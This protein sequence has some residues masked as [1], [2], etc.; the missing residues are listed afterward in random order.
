MSA[1][2]QSQKFARFYRCALQVNPFDY[3]QRHAVPTAPKNE[4]IYNSNLIAALEHNNIEAI[5]VTDH[6]RVT[7]SERLTEAARSKGIHAFRGFEAVTKDG[8]HFLCIFDS[9]ETVARLERFIGECGVHDTKSPSPLGTLD[10]EQ[11][12][13]RVPDWG[14]ICVAAHVVSDGGILR[15]LKGTSRANLWKS[16]LLVACAL[17]GSPTSAPEDLKRILSNADP[18]YQ[19]RWPMAFIN[20]QDLSDATVAG[21][22]SKSCLI[23]MTSPS[24][25][26]LRQAF[27]DSESRIRLLSEPT[28]VRNFELL[29]I[30]WDGG[31]LDGLGIDFSEHLNCVI[32]GRGTG[33]STLIESIRAVFGIKPLGSEATKRH[34]AIVQHVIR[35]GTKITARVAIHRPQRTEYTIE[36]ILPDAP[37]VRTSDG[38]KTKLRP[39]ELVPGFEIYG[40]HEIS[41]LAS[42]PLRL[43]ELLSR[44]LPSKGEEWFDLPA[45]QHELQRSR[46][47]ID[48]LGKRMAGLEDR[49]TSLPRLQEQKERFE[50]AG[51][52][53]VLAEQTAVISEAA[54]LVAFTERL[55]PFKQLLDEFDELLPV[56]WEDETLSTFAESPLKNE[57][58]RM[59]QDLLIF[60]RSAKKARDLLAKSIEDADVGDAQVISKHSERKE[61]ITKKTSSVFRKLG[62]AS[63]DGQVYIN[64]KTQIA[65]LLPLEPQLQKLKQQ[66]ADQTSTRDELVRRLEDRKAAQYRALEKAAKSV[67]KRL[68]GSVRVSVKFQG[69]REPLWKQ[70]KTAGGRWSETLQALDANDSIT[71]TGLARSIR[72]GVSSLQSNFKLPRASAE[73]LAGLSDSEVMQLEETTLD[74]TTQIELNVAPK[75]ADPIWRRLDQLSAGQRATAVLLLLLLDNPAPLIVDQP[76]D[77]LDNRFIYDGIVPKLRSEKHSRQF[78]FATHNANIPVLGDA[79]LIACFQATGDGVSGRAELVPENVGSID[80]PELRLLVEQVLEGGS[81]AF[82]MRRKKYRY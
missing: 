53:Q 70:L 45:I 61:E 4:D 42:D 31:F 39:N 32:G 72:E 28:P 44:F 15:Q 18:V 9:G 21:E 30:Q 34:E 12:L 41:E 73:R 60:N 56:Q 78:I 38:K 2:P 6:Y 79:E 3:V 25:E 35:P 40:Q 26:A 43:T 16:E 74:H 57:I 58:A 5:C 82:E 20:A 47:G 75:T 10:S 22:F 65:Q 50:K 66:F 69:A 8:V 14:G 54:E 33:K 80:M 7:T 19:R 59:K 36:R 23:K 37:L 27:L 29:D 55:D 51:F 76:E 71:A 77:D 13:E 46:S 17:A 1:K 68:R 67:S 64:T 81:E 48:Q 49:L 62:S 11:L 63:A 24:V 52:A